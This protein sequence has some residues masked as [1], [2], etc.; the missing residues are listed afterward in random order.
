MKSHNNIVPKEVSSQ[1]EEEEKEEE[2]AGGGDGSG[3][4][5]AEGKE[6]LDEVLE[7]E[8]E[9]LELLDELLAGDTKCGTCGKVFC[10]KKLLYFHGRNQHVDL[11][12]CNICHKYFDS[13][14]KS[15]IHI[16]KTHTYGSESAKDI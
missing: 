3:A 16:Q 1:E 2:G 4:G 15:N 13:I 6:E 14:V 11:G 10:I 5:G 9:F 8:L 12:N 7:Q